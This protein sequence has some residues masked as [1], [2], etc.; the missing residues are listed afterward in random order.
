MRA[1]LRIT[2]KQYLFVI[3]FVLLLSSTLPGDDIDKSNLTEDEYSVLKVCEGVIQLFEQFPDSIW[4]GYDLSRQP[5]IVYFPEKWALLINYSKEADG[6]KP[7]PEDWPRIGENVLYYEGQYRDLAGQLAFYVPVDTIEVAAVGYREHSQME[8]FK[9]IV[10]EAFHEYQYDKFGEIPWERE[11]KY[12]I[13]DRENTALACLEMHLLTDALKASKAD[14]R[15]KCLEYVRQFVAVRDYRWNRADPFIRKYEQGQE[16]NEGTAKYVESKSVSL[17]AGLK[18]ESTMTDPAGPIL[19]Q[20]S[21]VTMPELIMRDMRERFTGKSISPED[22]P[23]NRIYSVGSAQG[24]LLDYFDIDWKAEAQ[25]AG[26]TYTFAG[27]FKEHLDIDDSQMRQLFDNARANYNYEGILASSDTLV[28]EYV[29]GFKAALESFESQ[30][31]YRMEI[32]LKSNGVM[33]SRHSRSKKWVVDNGTRELCGHFNI[34]TLTKNELLL[35]VENTALLE[36]NDWD[37]KTKKVVFFIP[38]IASINLN[39]EPVKPTDGIKY[40]FDKIEILGPNMKFSYS[41][42]GTAIFEGNRVSINLII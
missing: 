36:Q 34:Y 39:G 1:I 32:D 17:L 8:L 7:Y 31:G 11:Q 12:P 26:S 25:Q 29:D 20:F 4:L 14:M 33:R 13:Q 24:Y 6:F 10:H 9:Y 38:E 16:I 35:Q 23:R 22:V 37:K 3:L 27:L 40:R 5:F 21:S 41:K 15:E 2:D 42:S 18:Y 19:D 30:T 28:N